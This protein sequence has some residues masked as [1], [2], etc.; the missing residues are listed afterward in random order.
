MPHHCLDVWG[1]D[2]FWFPFPLFLSRAKGVD[3]SLIPTIRSKRLIIRNI[4][5]TKHFP[6]SLWL[7]RRS[8]P[9]WPFFWDQNLIEHLRIEVWTLLSSTCFAEKRV[10]KKYK[11]SGNFDGWFGKVFCLGI[12]VCVKL[13]C[14]KGWHGVKWTVC[15]RNQTVSARQTHCLSKTDNKFKDETYVVIL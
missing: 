7:N 8:S 10:G 14:F 12:H 9:C 1:C 2:E 5:C 15:C 6:F 11:A 4:A 3:S 13:L